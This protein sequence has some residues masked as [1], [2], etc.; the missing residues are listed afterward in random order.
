MNL[1]IGSGLIK[2]MP[3]KSPRNFATR[4]TSG[5]VRSA[6]LDM[7]AAIWQGARVLDG[8]AGTGANGLEAWS[9]GAASVTFVESDP[10]AIRAITANVELAKKR[11]IS[12][13]LPASGLLVLP[14]A[15]ENVAK[16]L[17]GRGFDVIWLD[18]PY[19]I[20]GQILPLIMPDLIL[21]LNPSGTIVV[22]LG[23]DPIDFSL[24]NLSLI[25]S[26]RY[27]ITNIFILRTEE[28]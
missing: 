1:R 27:G 28:A 12:Q 4:P 5:K 22:E 24:W 21:R 20:A 3:L 19:A 17:V 26:K 18:P 23:D 9:R 16:S 14:G 6:V 15:I 10:L 13:G 8:F 7:L 2:G 25:K 11:T